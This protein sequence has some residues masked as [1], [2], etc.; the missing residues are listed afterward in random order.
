MSHLLCCTLLIMRS[1][2]SSY[3][4]TTVSHASGFAG[5]LMTIHSLPLEC[6]L[7]IV[8]CA[9]PRCLQVCKLFHL[10]VLRCRDSIEGGGVTEFH[11]LSRSLR[12]YRIH[13][14]SDCSVLERAVMVLERLGSV[15]TVSLTCTATS[16]I[17]PLMQSLRCLSLCTTGVDVALLRAA[18]P[19]A[20]GLEALEL[21]G[22]DGCGTELMQAL[23]EC[24][25]LQ[26]LELVDSNFA[27][28]TR[29]FGL[30]I[31]S[32]HICHQ[33][34][35]APDFA[36]ACEKVDASDTLEYIALDWREPVVDDAVLR[37]IYSAQN[38]K[39]L[40][41]TCRD[42]ASLFPRFLENLAC[43]CTLRELRMDDLQR[44]APVAGVSFKSLEKIVFRDYSSPERPIKYHFLRSLPKLRSLTVAT[45]TGGCF[46]Q[47]T[48]LTGLR[49]L[50]IVADA[51]HVETHLSAAAV[52][53]VM[54]L[55]PRL[56]SLRLSRGLFAPSDVERL[57]AV[58]G[59]HPCV[60]TEVPP[61]DD[62]DGVLTGA[63]V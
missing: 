11:V 49:D 37:T 54:R 24:N 29:V 56:A 5:P 23:S 61:V 8:A 33:D 14:G 13:C 6:L 18:L 44:V 32:L 16:G 9:G 7:R 22:V 4:A 10:L 19:Q 3:T 52:E 1:T 15:D 25:S 53:N 30:G 60:L 34:L 40:C 51:I 17:V 39:T 31:R 28:W 58:A 47:F 50:S 42:F 59:R 38:V 57:C 20:E 55:V 26:R 48:C 62:F 36:A 35:E 46:P 41:V 43:A 45:W 21:W 2:N 12:C 63:D 27:N